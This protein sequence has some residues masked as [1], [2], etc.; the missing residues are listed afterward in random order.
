MQIIIRLEARLQPNTGFTLQR[1]LAVFTRSAITES[2]PI[3]M[4]S[5]ALWVHC[6]GLAW[7]ILGAIRT[8]LR[9]RR[10]SVFCQVINARFHQFPVGQISR[11]L[12]TTRRSVSWWKFLKQNFENY[13]VRGRWSKKRK[14]FSNIFKRLATSSVHNSAM[15][16][17]RRKFTRE[18]SLY[19]T[20]SFHFYSWN[21]FKAIPLVSTLRTGNVLP[22]FS[23]TSDAGWQHGR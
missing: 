2:E 21:K 1:V 15:I 23:D 10:N 7:Q 4:K 9:A 6:R 16:I 11:N 22:N 3:W 12:N 17:D 19:G 14:N 13:T 5:G 18:W 20:S 8:S